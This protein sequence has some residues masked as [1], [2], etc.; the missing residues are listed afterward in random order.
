[1]KTIADCGKRAQ[2]KN[3]K[4][5][6]VFMAVRFILGRSGTGKTSYC[7]NSIVSELQE[8]GEQ[9]LIL[10][11]PEQA[12]YQAE[13]AVLADKSI[14]GYHRL[15]ILSFDRLQYLLL[16]KNTA[17]PAISRIG[18]QMIIHRLLRDNKSRLK[19]F[20][21]SAAWL[22][23][24]RKLAHTVE[25]LYQYAQTPDDIDRLLDELAKDESNSLATLK[26]TDI[27]LIFDEY[28]KFI[29][30]GFID[31]DAQLTSACKVIPDAGLAKGAKLWVDGFAG[32]TE[33]EFAVLTELLK[34]VSDAQIAL[35]LDPS[36]IDL[37]NPEFGEVDLFNPTLRTYSELIDR[38]K[39]YELQLTKPKILKQA[40]RFSTCPQLAHVES[41]IFELK[42]SKL[43]SADNIR[44]VSAPNARAE[45]QFVV[46]QIL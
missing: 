39:K 32:F 22:G 24:S 28:L 16:G 11:V 5:G 33:A 12:T 18:R 13:R 42:P 9:K 45:V 46:R 4:S 2:K 23:L 21:T 29:E 30:G 14:A 44:L 3:F 10:L 31:P 38:V 17:R 34:V 25:E 36:V 26:F 40:L 35:C 19:I 15:N 8:P 43:N 7:V 27:R 1:L 6:I 41:N 20:D 37:A